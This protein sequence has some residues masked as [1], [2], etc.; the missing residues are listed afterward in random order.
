MLGTGLI[1]ITY[2]TNSLTFANLLEQPYRHEG[3]A[4]RGRTVRQWDLSSIMS[5]TDA[6]ALEGLYQAYRTAK[7]LE[8]DPVRTGVVGATVALSGVAPG[9]SWS[10]AVPCWF[11][12]APSMPM[13]GAFMRVSCSLEAAADALAVLLRAGEEEAEQTAQQGLGTTTR[14]GV[15][16][17][18]TA[19]GLNFE[20]TPQLAL[21]PGGRHVITGPAGGP[22]KT[23]QI[24]G[25]VPEA[26]LATLEAW[27]EAATQASPTQ[28]QW[29][30]TA[31]TE[32]AWRR[33]ADAGVIGNF[34]DVSFTEVYIR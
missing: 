29:F 34:Y 23:R 22:T 12:A 18:L 32:P 6:A 30:P 11:V 13:A 16:I 10:T 33:R 17:T 15:T 7:L 8:D 2:G 27:F 26:Q 25:Y 28:G 24:T 1:T 5:R 20:D 31:W 19:R 3:D 4:R 14:G 21:T 9:F